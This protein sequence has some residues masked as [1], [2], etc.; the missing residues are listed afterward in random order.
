MFLAQVS[1]AFRCAITLRDLINPYLLRRKKADVNAD[2]PN[3]TEQVSEFLALLRPASDRPPRCVTNRN[4][5][6]L[7]T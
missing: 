6:F 2:L 4:P 7:F 3:R 1:T 5:M